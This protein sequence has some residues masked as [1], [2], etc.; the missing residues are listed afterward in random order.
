ML[1]GSNSNLNGRRDVDLI[2][3]CCDSD[4]C[5]TFDEPDKVSP[6]TIPTVHSPSNT[7]QGYS[8]NCQEVDSEFCRLL[9]HDYRCHDSNVTAMCPRTCGKCS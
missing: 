5:N 7:N 3:G 4:L 2:G 6:P 8:Q 1:Y 9:V